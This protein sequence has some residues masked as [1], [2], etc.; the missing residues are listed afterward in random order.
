MKYSVHYQKFNM[1]QTSPNT[2]Q[3]NFQEYVF[4]YLSKA[5]NPFSNAE[6]YIKCT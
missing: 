3:V 2:K 6:K 1:I 4:K 5:C